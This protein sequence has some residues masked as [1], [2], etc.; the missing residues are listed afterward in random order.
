VK[1]RVFRIIWILLARDRVTSRCRADH[2]I[3]TFVV[4]VD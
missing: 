1:R 3:H 2:R 4:F